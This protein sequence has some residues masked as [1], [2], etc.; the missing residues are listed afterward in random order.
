MPHLEQCRQE[1]LAALQGLTPAQWSF[2]PSAGACSVTEAAEHPG[3]PEAVADL[4]TRPGV[5]WLR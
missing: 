5:N 2:K 3:V 4:P 1:F